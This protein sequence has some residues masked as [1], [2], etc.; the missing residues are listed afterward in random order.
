M[1][2]NLSIKCQ[3]GVF[4]GVDEGTHV[5]WKGIPFAKP[6]VGERRFKAPEKPDDSDETFVCDTYAHKP[7]QP[8][9][10]LDD[11]SEDC[12]YLN[13]Y[14]KDNGKNNKSVMVWIH[15]G[16]YLV[17]STSEYPMDSL[18]KEYGDDVVFVNIEYRLGVMGFGGLN[19]VEGSEDYKGSSN[20]GLRDQIRALEWIHDNIK[21]F[22]GDVNNV[23]IFGESAGGG[24][25]SLLPIALKHQNRKND[26]FHRVIAQSGNPNFAYTPGADKE[27]V[28]ILMEQTGAKNMKDLIA[29]STADIQNALIQ[30]MRYNPAPVF[31][32][33][34]LPNSYKEALELSKSEE[35]LELD[36]ML[37][38]NADECRYLLLYCFNKET[39]KCNTEN[40]DGYLKYKLDKA[41]K[42][43]SAEDSKLI[44]EYLNKITIDKDKDSGSVEGWKNTAVF[45]AFSFYIPTYDVADL[46]AECG[47][48]TYMYFFK[49][50]SACSA[51]GAAHGV[52]VFSAFN[53]PA[54]KSILDATLDDNVTFSKN[55]SSLWVNFAKNGIPTCDA[56]DWSKHPYVKGSP[57][58]L[59][60][61]KDGS[62]RIDKNIHELEKEYILP[63]HRKDPEEVSRCYWTIEPEMFAMFLHA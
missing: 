14:T 50:E 9:A 34:T 26:L 41:R 45:N 6:P 62:M 40:Y 33:I 56:M 51:V 27:Q 11:V 28:R 19:N 46:R 29:L 15:G 59:I 20:N 52:E 44:D 37:G 38:S 3:N 16:A 36:W 48:K 21:G 22:G 53:E 54:P 31:D 24:S 35:I 55:M 43:M 30:V 7:L 4:V 58:V 1:S 39:G 25:V 13:I 23:T 2:N 5:T 32:G 57:E 10:A 61:E 63:L 42:T 17:G 12:L 47:V 60:F 8:L 18:A 49:P